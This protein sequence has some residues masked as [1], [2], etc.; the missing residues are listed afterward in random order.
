MQNIPN[1]HTIEHNYVFFTYMAAIL[2]I[3]NC[4]TVA[5]CHPHGI[6]HWDPIHVD[7]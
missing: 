1:L 7:E 6:V 4:S 5:T 2:N 3:S